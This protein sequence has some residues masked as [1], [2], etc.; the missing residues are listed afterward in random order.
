[1]FKEL[2]L[3]FMVDRPKEEEDTRNKGRLETMRL[4][5]DERQ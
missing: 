4:L 3:A 1:M 2:S 5:Y